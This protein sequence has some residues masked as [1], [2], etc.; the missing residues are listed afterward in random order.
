MI[1]TRLEELLLKQEARRY[2]ITIGD[3]PLSILPVPPGKTIIVT[4]IDII[5]TINAPGSNVEDPARTC[6]QILEQFYKMYNTTP[7]DITYLTGI[8]DDLY[9]SLEKTVSRSVVQLI[10]QS[11]KIN[12]TYTCCPSLFYK[13]NLDFVVDGNLSSGYGYKISAD[14]S[15]QTQNYNFDVYSIHADDVHFRWA[16][17]YAVMVNSTT[18]TFNPLNVDYLNPNYVAS[19][20][21]SS[22]YE[23]NM[24]LGLKNIAVQILISSLY[25]YPTAL[26]GAW[27]PTGLQQLSPNGVTAATNTQAFDFIRYPLMFETVVSNNENL[28]SHTVDYGYNVAGLSPS[29]VFYDSIFE[30]IGKPKANIGYCV[31]NKNL[32]F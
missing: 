27:I 3:G 29:L 1:T 13:P 15:Y 24:P 4:D 23:S 9:L 30:Y 16:Y 14:T 11:E 12:N 20:I 10:E 31:I 8:Y 7:V 19:F 2:Q 26:L 22:I 28:A 5:P 21:K 17:P 6:I 18:P 25:N 32:T